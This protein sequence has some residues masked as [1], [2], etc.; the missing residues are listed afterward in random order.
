M[1]RHYIYAHPALITSGVAYF[2]STD[3]SRVSYIGYCL[4]KSSSKFCL[5]HTQEKENKR[6]NTL[7]NL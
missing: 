7:K 5:T 4:L 2:K 3:T 1:T 6:N